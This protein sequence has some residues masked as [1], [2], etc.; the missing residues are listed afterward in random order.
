MNNIKSITDATRV[1][2]TFA[3]VP[4][5]ANVRLECPRRCRVS[6]YIGGGLGVS[7]AVLDIERIDHPN[8]SV[9]GSDSDAVFAYQ[10]FAGLRLALNDAMGLSL[11]YRYFASEGPRW[12]GDVDFSEGSIHFGRI[13]THS[14]S[15]AFDFHF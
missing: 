10:G 4:F 6:P 9:R 11:E 8:A 12:K 5:L 13:E 1:D 15:V 7:A 2:A 14:V 3:N